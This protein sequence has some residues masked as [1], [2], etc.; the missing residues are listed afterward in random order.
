MSETFDIVIAG[1]AVMGS[2]TAYHLAAHPGFSG[3]VLVIEPDST[4]QRAASALSLS[5]IRQQ[6]STSINI[7]VGMFGASFLRKAKQTLAVDG[8][9]PE[10]SF[11]ESGYLYLAGD[12]GAPILRENHV[13]QKAEG[14]DMILLDAAALAARFP[15]LDL[16]G[17]TLGSL[18]QSNE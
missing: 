13:A 4:Y 1:G 18:G 16:D 8:N 17:V 12:A 7:Q 11:K 9:E 2:S 14:A 10:L 15:F 6:F 3:R 5:S